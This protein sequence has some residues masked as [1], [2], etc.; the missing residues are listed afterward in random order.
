MSSKLDHKTEKAQ[1]FSQTQSLFIKICQT[2]VSVPAVQQQQKKNRRN[3]RVRILMKSQIQR[4]TENQVQGKP[5][6]SQQR[7]SR[8][9]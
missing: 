3:I 4:S 2:F 7:G 8:V 9:F 5:I 6:I 1:I